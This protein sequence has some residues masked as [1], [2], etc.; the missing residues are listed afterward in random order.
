MISSFLCICE[1]LMQFFLMQLG[2]LRS[3]KCGVLESLLCWV[4]GPSRDSAKRPG[5]RGD[6]N[7]GGELSSPS[8]DAIDRSSGKLRQCN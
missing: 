5:T 6:T 7:K 1:L 2:L 4:I 8:G 3:W